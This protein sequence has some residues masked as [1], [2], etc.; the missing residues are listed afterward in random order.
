MNKEFNIEDLFK[1]NFDGHKVEPKANVWNGIS[2]T[3]WKR[4]LRGFFKLSFENYQVLPSVA[5]WSS[6]ARRLWFYNFLRFNPASFNVYYLGLA[7]SVITGIM[8][9]SNL[10][11]ENLSKLIQQQYLNENTITKNTIAP[12]NITSQN[13]QPV[14]NNQEI[15]NTI[16]P[17]VENTNATKTDI[18]RIPVANNTNKFV[19][20]NNTA[21]QQVLHTVFNNPELTKKETLEEKTLTAFNSTNTNAVSTDQSNSFGAS[22]KNIELSLVKSRTPFLKLS[23]GNEV[24]MPDTLGFNFFGAP[25][26]FDKIHWSVDAW[27]SPIYNST[28]YSNAK[29]EFTEYTGLLKNSSSEDI[30]YSSYGADLNYSYKNWIFQIGISYS[31]LGQKMRVPNTIND[32]RQNSHYNYFDNNVLIRDTLWFID[33]DSLLQNPNDTVWLPKPVDSWQLQHDST[34]V[35]INDTLKIT[36]N[37]IVSNRYSYL[38]IPVMAGYE[39]RKGKISYAVKGGLAA[40]F[41]IRSSGSIPAENGYE[42]VSLNNTEFPYIKPNFTLLFSLGINYHLNNKLAIFGEPYI[43]KNLNSIF[44]NRYIYSQKFQA[45]GV[46]FGIKYTFK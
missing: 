16:Q 30:T 39:I 13:T 31:E 26:V 46:K 32:I 6:I 2:K 5:I 8:I 35:T 22:D 9:S 42:N 7:V 41:F 17:I 25:I 37:H 14:N 20:K 1:D 45:V 4:E 10:K 38:E 29:P 33:L 43:R 44:E 28:L 3:L 11:N 15:K 34:L 18:V 19:K 40:G 24:S 23:S 12:K 27:W 36:S 21:Q